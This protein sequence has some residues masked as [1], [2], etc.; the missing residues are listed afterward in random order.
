MQHEVYES[1][2][3]AFV[4]GTSHKGNT[5]PQAAGQIISDLIDNRLWKM[6]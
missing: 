3:I 1:K 6:G 4:I 2:R 5:L